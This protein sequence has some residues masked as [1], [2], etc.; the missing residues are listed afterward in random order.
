MIK[1][2]HPASQFRY[3]YRPSRVKLPRWVFK[4]WAWL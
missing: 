2:S 3:V 4:V 1:T